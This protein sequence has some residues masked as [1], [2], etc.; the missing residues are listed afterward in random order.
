MNCSY[1]KQEIEQGTGSILARRDGKVARFCSN[2]CRK[3][4]NMKRDPKKLKW[5][6]KTK[7][8]KGEKK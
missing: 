2:K 5:I 4:H 3:N 7:K 8:V 6:T 1:C